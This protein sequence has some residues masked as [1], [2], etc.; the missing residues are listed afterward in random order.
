MRRSAFLALFL[1][2]CAALFVLQR[3]QVGAPITPR[4]LLYLVADTQREAE[5]IPLAI[6]RVSDQDE[7]KIGEEIARGYGLTSKT[8]DDRDTAQIS[9]YLNSVGGM[10]AEHVQRRG[11]PYHFYLDDRGSF[12]NAFA[13][14]GGHIVVGRGLLEL[15]ESEDEL[16]AILGHE[17][18]HVDNRHAI[19]RVQY[20]RASR[21]LGLASIY[22]LGA[23]AV[24][25]FQAGYTKDQEL[26]ADR[27]GLSL[28]VTAGYSA[29]GGINL[30][31][32]FQQVESDYTQRADS[33]I[34]EFAG[35]PFSTLME[36][37]RSHPPA[38][39]RRAAL[40]TEAFTRGWDLSQAVRP[41]KIRAIFL[42]DA[43]ESLDRAGNF[44][45]SISHFK[46]A[47][48]SNPDYVRARQ[49]LAQ[50][51]WRSGDAQ[52]AAETAAAA[53]QRAA[54]ASD[55][56]LLARA[57]AVSEPKD[58]LNRFDALVKEIYLAPDWS[59][60]SYTVAR[61]ES[62]GLA[63]LRSGK[64]ALRQ[65]YA[66]LSALPQGA[67][68]QSF[69]RREMGWW[70]YR[71][72]KLDLAAS[73]LETARQ[74]MP[75]SQQANLRA[76]W[77]LSDLGRQADAERLATAGAMGIQAQASP[78]ADQRAE[79]QAVLAVLKWRTEQRQAAALQ[80][81][82]AASKDPVW[83]VRRWVENNYSSAAAETL[84]HLQSLESSRRSKEKQ[85]TSQLLH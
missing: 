17:I 75:Q 74:L 22:Q 38:S 44:A 54:T 52:G 21:K 3:S 11:I 68:D 8:S 53:I 9:A 26:E 80:F 36:Y 48:N 77:V 82:E 65:Y 55:W 71:S 30:I 41:F 7:V 83:M 24:E 39:E 59:N 42:T 10:L 69:A 35:L 60:D 50:T 61:V 70:M 25:I 79:R 81:Q 13:L 45:A 27:A 29:G 49:G 76:A 51:S 56:M 63:F 58:A 43:A 19:E 84:E 28:A 5:R 6:T 32:R 78:S 67:S 16:A 46:E 73:E 2:G 4:P 66:V 20:E 15:I 1:A 12:V 34:E 18:A 37:F 23:P 57:L 72:G 64:N 33:P 85:Q 47:I 14:P 62:A 31:N 40:Q